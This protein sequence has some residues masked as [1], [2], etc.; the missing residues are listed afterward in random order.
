[1]VPPASHGIS[2]VPSYSG[3][4]YAEPAFA[5]ETVTLFGAAFQP[6]SASFVRSIMPARNPALRRVRFGL[7]PFRSPLL[8]KS[9]FLS[10]PPATKM[11]QFT[12]CP[13]HDY[14]F[15]IR[16]RDITHGGFPHSEIHGSKP[17][18]GSPWH[19]AAYRVLRRQ[20]VPRHSPYALVRLI[21]NSLLTTIN[22]L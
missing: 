21:L 18:C 15:I 7:L 14:G 16:Y 19:I 13:P 8:R 5:Y 9:I 4:G 20:C 22:K 2:R 12:G 6:P 1:M 17:A 10:F 3:T 11:F